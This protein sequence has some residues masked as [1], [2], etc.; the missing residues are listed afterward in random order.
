MVSLL[1]D[2]EK[3]K[4][5][6]RI[7]ADLDGSIKLSQLS[8]YNFAQADLE[9]YIV[10]DSLLLDSPED[11]INLRISGMD[12]RIGPESKT[13]RMDTTRTFKLLAVTGRIKEADATYKDVVSFKGKAIDLAFSDLYIKYSSLIE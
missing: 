6:G 7:S 4:A 2:T 8:I 11:T 9:G 3:V 1:P 10:C 12:F 13:S 5:G